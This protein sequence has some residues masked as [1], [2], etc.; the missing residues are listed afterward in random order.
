MCLCFPVSFIILMKLVNIV[1]LPK[2]KALYKYIDLTFE[3]YEEYLEISFF[4]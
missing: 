3:A 4:G 2:K 1:A